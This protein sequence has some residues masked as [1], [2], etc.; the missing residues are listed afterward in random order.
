[1]ELAPDPAPP[2]YRLWLLAGLLISLVIGTVIWFFLI[3]RRALKQTEPSRKI[4]ASYIDNQTCAEC[5]R[6]AFQ[7]WTG[8]DH[9]WRW[10]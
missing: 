4:N 2:S 9:Q 6:Q 5:H 1:M 7:D 10:P 8:S 3:H